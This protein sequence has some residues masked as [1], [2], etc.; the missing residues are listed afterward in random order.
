MP[1]SSA[2]SVYN[3]RWNAGGSYRFGSEYNKLFSIQNIFC[4]RYATS[5]GVSR[6]ESGSVSPSGG[7]QVSGSYQYSGPDGVVYTVHF[8]ADENGYRPRWERASHHQDIN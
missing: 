6:S 8:V 7:Y 3:E 5:N 2:T 4:S 1:S